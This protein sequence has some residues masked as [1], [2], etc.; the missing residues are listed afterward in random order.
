MKPSK[1]LSFFVFLTVINLILTA[2]CAVLYTQV[3]SMTFKIRDYYAYT[4]EKQDSN[5]YWSIGEIQVNWFYSSSESQI[6][7]YLIREPIDLEHKHEVQIQIQLNKGSTQIWR[8][9]YQWR[10][11]IGSQWYEYIFP[12][13]VEGLD[14]KFIIRIQM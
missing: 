2:S 11:D 14:Y 9:A 1:S 13:P 4:V 12:R 3:V 8:T 6:R 7:I 5:S 10:S